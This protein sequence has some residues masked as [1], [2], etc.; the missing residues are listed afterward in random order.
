MEQ[1]KVQLGQHAGQLEDLKSANGQPNPASSGTTSQAT[2]TEETPLVSAAPSIS[3][4]RTEDSG[5]AIPS[6]KP[7]SLVKV[8]FHLKLNVLMLHFFPRIAPP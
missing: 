5:Q 3:D 1:Q 2:A 7:V 6:P 8:V 4:S